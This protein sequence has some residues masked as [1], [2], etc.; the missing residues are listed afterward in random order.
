MG[1]NTLSFHF[2]DGIPVS[3]LEQFTQMCKYSLLPYAYTENI[4]RPIKLC[5]NSKICLLDFSYSFWTRLFLNEYKWH[6]DKSILRWQKHSHSSQVHTL[7]ETSYSREGGKRLF[8]TLAVI[9]SSNS[10]WECSQTP[11]LL[12]TTGWHILSIKVIDKL[13]AIFSNC[14]PQLL[15]FISTL[16]TQPLMAVHSTASEH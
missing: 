3:Y 15:S 7:S 6:C 4:N 2:K 5:F 11:T 1:V 16:P 13:I 10:S 8:W 14:F 9:W 12:V